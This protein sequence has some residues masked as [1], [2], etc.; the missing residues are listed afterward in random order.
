MTDTPTQETL[1]N[2]LTY[3][4]LPAYNEEKNIRS[5]LTSFTQ[6][7]P[8]AH[9][10][11]HV[12][13]NNSKDA[14]Y[15]NAMQ[16]ARNDSRISVS[17]IPERVGKGGAI[18]YGFSQVKEGRLLG[19][20]DADGS[21]VPEAV[22]RLL[23]EFDADSNLDVAISSRW[24]KGSELAKKQSLI[25]Q[26]TS[27]SFNL[28][29]RVLFGFPYRDT[30]CGAKILRYS[31]WQQI[32]TKVRE[33]SFAFDIDLLWQAKKAGLSIKE[34]AIPWHDTP[35]SS[36]NIMQSAWPIVSSLFRIRFKSGDNS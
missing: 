34:I 23:A 16:E 24:L 31:G 29:I 10:R 19:F 33:K 14:T 3:L 12:V 25:R 2:A 1:G 13:V 15:T 32:A 30:Q 18:L 17:N 5:V 7:F 9:F 22:R 4:I 36:V 8:A 6:A 27:R 28:L 35:G 20:I 26:L 11:F 21:I